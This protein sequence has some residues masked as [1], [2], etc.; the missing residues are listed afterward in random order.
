MASAFD[1]SCFDGSRSK[2]R[3]FELE[4]L[5]TATAIDLFEV[6][7]GRRLV[8]FTYNQSVQTSVVKCRSK[9]DNMV[10]L[11]IRKICSTEERLGIVAWIERVPSQSNPSDGLSREVH[12]SYQGVK[13]TPANLPEVWQSCLQ[14][15]SN[16]L[17]VG[18]EARG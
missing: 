4:G 14:E 16:R 15:K 13:C 10:D 6:F 7:R 17:H 12:E 5:A 9:N 11:I 8:V 3:N 2:D 1:A 18:G